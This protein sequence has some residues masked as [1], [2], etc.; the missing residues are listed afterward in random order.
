[1]EAGRP[2]NA[3]ETRRQAGRAALMVALGRPL[4]PTAL[5]ATV[6]LRPTADVRRWTRRLLWL[7]AALLAGLVA[8]AWA[9]GEFTPLEDET[10]RDYLDHLLGLAMSPLLLL[11]LGCL[12]AAAML[13]LERRRRP[14][15]VRISLSD[16]EAIVEGPGGA[17]TTP[18]SEFAAV[19][20]RHVPRRTINRHAMESRPRSTFHRPPRQP[21]L[22]W[23]TLWWVELVH[24]D[25]ERSVPVWAAQTGPV[26][27]AGRHNAESMARHVAHGF[28]RR[29]D[30]PLEA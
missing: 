7:A 8:F 1:M 23:E 25:P 29:L 2:P 3:R 5:P 16:T 9:E 19:A 20:L 14:E 17:W 4:Y 27:S 6:E 26:P 18:V 28:A 11:P 15:W 21:L 22:K 10:A 13:E 30:L 12:G 24:P